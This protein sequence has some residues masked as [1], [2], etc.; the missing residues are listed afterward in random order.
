MEN[1]LLS[2]LPNLGVGVVAIGALI[3]VVNQFLNQLREIRVEHK[4]AMQERESAFRVLEK[5]VRTEILTQLS[6][7][8]AAMERVINHM[9]K[10]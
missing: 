6:R 8:T 5:E 1:T 3:Y 2:V 7:N 10:H 9:D 4:A